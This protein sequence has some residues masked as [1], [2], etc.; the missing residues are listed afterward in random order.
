MKFENMSKCRGCAALGCS[1]QDNKLANKNKLI[2]VS[3]GQYLL[4]QKFS[5]QNKNQ[6]FWEVK[7]G[8]GFGGRVIESK[9]S[10]A[11]LYEHWIFL[12]TCA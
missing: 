3:W 6:I 4:N 12:L 10:V 5:F 1:S 7:L 8:L 9:V 2:V 11:F